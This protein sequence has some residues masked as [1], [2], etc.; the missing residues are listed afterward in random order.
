M[1][2][3]VRVSLKEVDA[4]GHE[5]GFRDRLLSV[6]VRDDLTED[7]A[8]IRGEL[9]RRLTHGGV[10]LLLDGLDETY[11]R[12]RTVISQVEDLMAVVSQDVDALVTTRDVAYGHAATLGWDDLVLSP[13]SEAKR[14]VKAVLRHA[15]DKRPNL[16]QGREPHEWVDKRVRWVKGALAE[17]RTL[18]ETPLLPVLLALLASE[19]DLDT[20]PTSR[21]SILLAVVNDVVARYELGKRDAPTIGNL[22]ESAAETAALRAFA[23]EA[24]AILNANGRITLAELIPIVAAEILDYWGM[25]R[26]HAES[27]AKDMIQ[28]FD[29]SGIFVIAGARET[30]GPRISLFAE[31]GDA[32][33]AST[34]PE[35]II[36][37]V[38]S[39][40][41]GRQLE[42]LILAA[43]LNGYAAQALAGAAAENQ[44]RGLLYAAVRAYREGAV[45]SSKDLGA[46]CAGLIDDF[47]Q[48]TF[49][50]WESWSNLL[51]LPI[52]QDMRP[53]IEKAA[54][55]YD[56]GRHKLIQASLDMRFL[57]REELQ[58]RPESLLELL[59]ITDLPVL[60]RPPAKH[61]STVSLHELL[62]DSQLHDAQT[63]AADTLIGSVHEAIPAVVER[64]KDGPQ[65]LA[66]ELRRILIQRGFSAEA[67]EIREE[68]ASLTVP[69]WLRDHETDSERSLLEVLARHT[70]GELT[71]AQ[72]TRVDELAVLLET[73]RM[74][75][76]S[77]WHMFKKS[78]DIPAVV[79]LA[80]TLFDFDKHV[81]AA[82]AL[83]ILQ[84]MD[85]VGG[86]EPYYGLFD[87][88]RGR[89]SPNW[90][91]I[92]DPDNA[93]QLLGK[94]MTWGRAHALFAA[95]ALWE[96]PIA[97]SAAPMLRRLLPELVSSTTHQRIAA[98]TLTSLGGGP[99]P[100]C[101]L[102]CDDP[103]LRAVSAKWCDSDVEGNLTPEH[104]RLLEDP[105]GHVRK[106]AISRA[107]ELNPPGLDSLL[108]DIGSRPPV[109]WMCLSCRTTNPPDR[110]GCTKPK[111]NGASPNLS[112]HVQE[113]ISAME[114]ETAQGN[115]A[116]GGVEN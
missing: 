42:P 68:A 38:N 77:S 104:T 56:H 27:T 33:H 72:R 84:R 98:H 66:K 94:M 24:S 109:G 12:R 10:A 80:Q 102:E 59:T 79:D 51:H 75:D 89:D 21:A 91:P 11:D 58:E 71:Y 110:T 53:D 31:I 70:P 57:T 22:T 7:R 82:Q 60:K 115:G 100:E 73:L 1:P 78:N 4:L 113:L 62:A 67:A 74:N 69:A 16:A 95:S 20:L 29:T 105:D 46:V 34:Q 44:D 103:I 111:C 15:I 8:L 3:P 93:V 2:L 88:V 83:L 6:A 101:W 87:R 36:E 35:R 106:A 45:L 14:T 114:N 39:R 37:W 55:A 61:G 41:E 25:S 108:R 47:G 81:I 13:P 86:P 49:Q 63:A 85:A 40:I 26:G 43:G 96:A 48:G 19:K 17:D 76:A 99:E 112:K 50:S 107:A 97:D 30:V 90:E 116:G 52:T 28:F 5:S 9:E 54:R 92:T 64:A 32:L 23:S 18:E 65:T